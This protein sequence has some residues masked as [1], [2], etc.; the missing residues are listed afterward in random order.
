MLS[1]LLYIPHYCRQI[2]YNE[3]QNFFSQL[4][5]ATTNIGTSS[6]ITKAME[7]WWLELCKH[8][9]KNIYTFEIICIHDL[10]NT[11]KAELRR[12]LRDN[13]HS[14]SKFILFYSPAS[15]WLLS[16]LMGKLGWVNKRVGNS[17]FRLQK[18]NEWSCV[19]GLVVWYVCMCVCTRGCAHVC[20][21]LYVVYIMVYLFYESCNGIVWKECSCC[22]RKLMMDRVQDRLIKSFLSR[23][24]VFIADRIS[25]FLE[26]PY[27]III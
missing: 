4:I 12:H 3:T 21:L 20:T 18:L 2:F 9:F 14:W 27:N 24:W 7:Y 17:H 6:S 25:Y 26:Y 8:V 1:C 11:R 10:I 5:T 16:Y 22:S 13:F 23:W 15:C 19:K